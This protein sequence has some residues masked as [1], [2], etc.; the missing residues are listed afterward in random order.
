M[1][2][3]A[4]RPAPT[5]RARVGRPRLARLRAVP[6]AVTVTISVGAAGTPESER[7]LS[8]LR[9]LV[10]AAGADASI[11]VVDPEAEPN[12]G[13]VRLDPRSRV[14]TRHGVAL[15]LSRLEFDLL[16]FFARHRQQVFSR[17][18]L[19]LQ[20]W[21]HIHTTSR[22]VDVHISRLRTKVGEPDVIDT[23]YGVGYRLG[24][25]ATVVITEG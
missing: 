22:T 3:L 14:A 6:G 25:D 8:A 1:S 5:R 18:Q 11:V 21:G 20:V 19:L 4:T 15:D 17:S 24:E 10:A 23:V 13:A 12:V 2:V 16:L 7:V 9:D